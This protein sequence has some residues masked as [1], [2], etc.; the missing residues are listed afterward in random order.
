MKLKYWWLKT[1]LDYYED[2]TI[3]WL[4]LQ[5][6][7]NDFAV[8]YHKLCLFG[9]RKQSDILC[10]T[11]GETKVPYTAEDFSKEF[12]MDS[13]IVEKGLYILAKAKLIIQLDN[14]D[15]Y[16]PRLKEMV[17]G[18]EETIANH[19]RELA[20][21]RKRRERARKKLAEAMGKKMLPPGPKA[22]N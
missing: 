1:H 8:L 6:R 22:S 2:E 3:K 19:K 13:I 17:G 20:R 12:L 5:E 9:L 7:G 18:E 15:W 16:L 10:R 11:I 4:T 14:G 21:I